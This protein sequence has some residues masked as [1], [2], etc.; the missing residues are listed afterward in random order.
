[1]N[2]VQAQG[3]IATLLWTSGMGNRKSGPLVADQILTRLEAEGVVSF[4]SIL[5]PL[6]V[7]DDTGGVVQGE[8]TYPGTG[9]P[10][11]YVLDFDRDPE[12][13]EGLEA[14]VNAAAAAMELRIAL[15]TDRVEAQSDLD[16]IAEW[17]QHVAD[18][19]ENATLPD[20]AD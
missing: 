16:Q 17:R 3:L 5:R 10:E 13:I 20:N 2:H 9:K 14:D 15:M 12:S 19:R 4:P 1:M 8:Y 18:L 6:V 7:I 11:V